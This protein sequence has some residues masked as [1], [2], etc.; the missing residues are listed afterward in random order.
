MICSVNLLKIKAA[1]IHVQ[2]VKYERCMSRGFKVARFANQTCKCPPCGIAFSCSIALELH[3]MMSHKVTFSKD[4][5]PELIG[6]IKLLSGSSSDCS[7]VGINLECLL[8]SVKCEAIDDFVL[9]Y[10]FQC[11]YQ[12]LE[13]VYLP[14]S[15]KHFIHVNDRES[16]LH[17][18]KH[19]F[20]LQKVCLSNRLKKVKDMGHLENMGYLCTYCMIWCKS[21]PCFIL[22]LLGSA[23]R[24]YAEIQDQRNTNKI[25][26]TRS[27]EEKKR[28]P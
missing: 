14:S 18:Y 7:K 17:A 8:C 10:I 21:R 23:H 6:I 15:L 25:I 22:H 24:L 5:L 4:N 28:I 9:H 12:V 27:Q 16:H 19:K 11:A 26:Q 13:N 1:E 3:L 2:D 20:Q